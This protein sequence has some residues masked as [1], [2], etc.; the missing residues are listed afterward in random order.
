RAQKVFSAALRAPAGQ[1]DQTQLGSRLLEK[2]HLHRTGHHQ[3]TPVVLCASNEWLMKSQSGSTCPASAGMCR[4]RRWIR[5]T[6]NPGFRVEQIEVHDRLL[7]ILIES[8]HPVDCLESP[9][10]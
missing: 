9:A 2:T 10:A 6:Q 4:Y 1:A 5:D 3:C 8:R 7:V